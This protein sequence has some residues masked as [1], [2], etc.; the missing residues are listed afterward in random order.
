MADDDKSINVPQEGDRRK[1]I[2][3]RYRRC[4]STVRVALTLTE[5]LAVSKDNTALAWS[6]RAVR[7]IGDAVASRLAR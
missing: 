6:A 3:A 1:R 2:V 5:T 4:W 7:I